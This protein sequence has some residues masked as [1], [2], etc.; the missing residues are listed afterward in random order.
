MREEQRLGLVED[1]AGQYAATIL[2]AVQQEYPNDLRHPMIGPDDRPTPREIHPAF[3]GCY[4]WHSCVEMHWALMRLL[5]LAPGVLSAVDMRDV[6]D[7]HLTAEAL[8]TEAAYLSDHPG[9]K[10]PYGWGW[11]L[12]LAHEL[13]TWDDRDARRWSANIRP[14]ATTIVELFL[15]W[16]PHATYPSREGAHANTAFGLARALPCARA[17]AADGDQRLLD[18]IGEAAGRWYG[19]DTDYPA[20]WEPNG[21]DFLSPALAEAELMSEV[22]GAAAFADWLG[23]FLPRLDDGEPATLLEPAVVSD[24][25]DGQIAHL[26]GLNLYRAYAFRRVAGIL[27]AGDPRGPVL[28]DAARRHADASLAALETDGKVLVKGCCSPLSRPGWWAYQAVEPGLGR[29]RGRIRWRAVLAA[30]WQSC[31][32]RTAARG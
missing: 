10:R 24:P 14:L 8:A 1:L 2:R 29:C 21:A 25:T 18:A 32:R 22:L 23:R 13:A 20:G 9:F 26:H 28:R 31:P 27:P 15:A 7:D 5:R 16:L 6:L 11:V 19:N 17:R 4:D 3:Y 30:G 12:M